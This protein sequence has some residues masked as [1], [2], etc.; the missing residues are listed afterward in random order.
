VEGTVHEEQEINLP[1][2]CSGVARACCGA[3]I[4]PASQPEM[5]VYPSVSHIV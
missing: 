3:A 1:R 4:D 5:S 2:S